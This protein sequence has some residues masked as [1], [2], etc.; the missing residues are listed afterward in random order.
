[1]RGILANAVAII[2]CHNHPSGDLIPSD[3]DM[4]LTKQLVDAGEL[5]G[6]KVL[7]HLIVSNQ[8]YKS[9]VD[10]HKFPI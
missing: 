8:G 7:D 2:V 1:M 6:I 9:L 10:Y 3:A 4:E 5:L